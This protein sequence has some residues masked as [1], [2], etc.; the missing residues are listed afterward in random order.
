MSH[1]PKPPNNANN[2]LFDLG[3]V[4]L[5]TPF[6]AIVLVQ[7][8][9]F[10]WLQAIFEAN[11]NAELDNVFLSA[12][13]LALSLLWFL[14]RRWRYRASQ[15]STKLLSEIKR[16][17]QAEYAAKMSEARL[18]DAIENIPVAFVLRDADD[19]VVLFNKR[20]R[21]WNADVAHL[22]KPGVKFEIL[23]HAAKHR[24]KIEA[25]EGEDWVKLRLAKSHEISEPFEEL[26]SNGR[27]LRVEERRT[28]DGGYVGV[29]TDITE[30]KQSQNLLYDAIGTMAEG[31]ALYDS[32]ERMVMCNTPY[33]DTLPRLAALGVLEPGMKMEEIMNAGVS[34]GLVPPVYASNEAY[35]R[36][37]LERFRHPTGPFEFK[38]TNGQWIRSEEKKTLSGGTVGIRTN[39]TNRK[40]AEEALKESEGHLRSVVDN[41]PFLITLKDL[42]GRYILVNEA[43]AK[44]RNVS[45]EQALGRFARNHETSDQ[46]TIVEAH[47]REVIESRKTVERE[48]DLT[49]PD[50]TH[51]TRSVIK[52]PTY[53]DSGELTGVGTIST[54][55]TKRK[56]AETALRDS[57]ELFKSIIDNVP[58]QLF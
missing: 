1:A 7:L 38:T 53:S 16:R 25:V 45:V 46:A 17:E 18:R 12:W 54:D 56:Q 26:H 21:E 9:A 52:F 42:D 3:V 22:I 24:R 29:R 10:E 31:F 57:E 36:E 55:V 40:L 6:G 15:S 27:W 4:V 41:Y 33:R 19:R 2:W 28:N 43:F 47:D 8:D 13:I 5:A 51:V 34:A 14:W 48:R 44:S 35:L 30:L 58:S 50:G 37:R 20:Y 49:L 23:L 32:D 11:E 39:I